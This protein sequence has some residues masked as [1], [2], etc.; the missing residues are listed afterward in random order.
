[1]FIEGWRI[2]KAMD[3][4]DETL[5]GI[6][7]KGFCVCLSV[8]IFP[9]EYRW[10]LPVGRRQPIRIRCRRGHVATEERL[11]PANKPFTGHRCTSLSTP[12]EGRYPQVQQGT[13]PF[14][15]VL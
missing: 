5:L 6:S 10:V 12:Q 2:Q 14:V 8:V 1:E 13:T 15:P 9:Q 11:K 3:C 4:S 7:H